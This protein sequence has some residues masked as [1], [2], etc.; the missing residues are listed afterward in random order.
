[1]SASHEWLASIFMTLVLLHFL[2]AL[3]HGWVKR[4]GLLRR[5]AW[6]RANSN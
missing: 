4:D 5:M 1:M 6:G 3:W 2:A